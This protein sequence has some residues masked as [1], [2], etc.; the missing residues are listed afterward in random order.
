MIRMINKVTGS[1]MWVHESRLDE[2]LEA[3]HR[4]ASPPAVPSPAEPVKRPPARRKTAKK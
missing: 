3:G 2:Y 4:L 1:T